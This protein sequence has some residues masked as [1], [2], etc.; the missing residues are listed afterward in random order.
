MKNTI[1]GG[2]KYMTEYKPQ[3]DYSMPRQNG[4]YPPPPYIYPNMRA[5]LA[6]V[7]CKPGVKERFLPPEFEPIEYGLDI[8]F[9]T[10]Y[11]ES[12]LGPYNESLI[13]LYCSYKGNPGAYHMCSTSM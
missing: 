4:L 10:E 7:Q 11:P 3:I 1:I 12:S 13:L 5:I 8:I 2:K 6:V 9:I